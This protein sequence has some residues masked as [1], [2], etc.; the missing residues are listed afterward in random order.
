M[1]AKQKRLVAL[2]SAATIEVRHS[3]P[4]LPLAAGSD[5]GSTF[6]SGASNLAL[7][8]LSQAKLFAR[9]Q[10]VQVSLQGLKYK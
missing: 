10:M 3:M 9:K 4:P 6:M 8:R 7:G 5:I 1:E 2:Q